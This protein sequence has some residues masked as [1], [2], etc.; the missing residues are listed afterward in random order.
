MALRSLR[1]S[2]VS[3][4]SA[5]LSPLAAQLG[6][7]RWG[8]ELALRETIGVHDALLYTDYAGEAFVA[9]ETGAPL[10]GSPRIDF[11]AVTREKRRL[12]IGS[13]AALA[14]ERRLARSAD[15]VY[16]RVPPQLGLALYFWLRLG[17]R[18]LLQHD[19]PAARGEEPSA[20]MMRDLR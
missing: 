16:V 8:S 7:E 14:L 15:Q 12:G 4:L 20:W 10:R 2:D 13:R 11:V 19:W 3:A 18:P 1:P 6:C 17:Y 9:Y 5:W